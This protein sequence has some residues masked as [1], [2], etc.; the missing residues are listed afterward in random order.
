MGMVTISTAALDV[1]EGIGTGSTSE[2]GSTVLCRAELTAG[3]RAARFVAS[4]YSN[5]GEERQASGAGY[6]I[7]EAGWTL[8]AVGEDCSLTASG[9]TVDFTVT[10]ESGTS[11]WIGHLAISFTQNYSAA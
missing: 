1:A 9:A 8:N 11:D 2:T 7:P 10:G 4:A 6:M 5:R 3:E